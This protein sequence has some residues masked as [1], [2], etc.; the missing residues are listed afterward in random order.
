MGYF[1][2]FPLYKRR[3]QEPSLTL[4]EH[5]EQQKD[6]LPNTAAPYYYQDPTATATPSSQPVAA[7]SFGHTSCSSSKV[8]PYDAYQLMYQHTYISADPPMLMI[9]PRRD[10]LHRKCAT[11][12][13]AGSLPASHLTSQ[14]PTARGAEM[15]PTGGSVTATVDN[16]FHPKVHSISAT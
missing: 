2:F 15:T 14:G 9:P 5:N 7:T 10:T 1:R 6:N 3:K 16:T 13:A 12:I 11:L 8:P 4:V